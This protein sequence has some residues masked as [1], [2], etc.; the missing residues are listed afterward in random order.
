[1]KTT[2]QAAEPIF[3]KVR[4]NLN[5]ARGFDADN[6]RSICESMGAGGRMASVAERHRFENA[7]IVI[8]GTKIPMKSWKDGVV[9]IFIGKKSDTPPG[10]EYIGPKDRVSKV[11]ARLRR[12]AKEKA[13][14]AA[15]DAQAEAAY[16]RDAW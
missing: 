16:V 1:M 8:S 4:I 14:K 7:E 5:M 11:I 2:R 6:F 13:A 15:A 12:F 10:A 3:P 9:L